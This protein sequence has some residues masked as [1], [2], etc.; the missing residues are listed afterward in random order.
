MPKRFSEEKWKQKEQELIE[1]AKK[2]PDVNSDKLSKS[3]YYSTFQTRFDNNMGLL[4]KAAELPETIPEI[5]QYVFEKSLEL[6]HPNSLDHLFKADEIYS[7][8]FAEYQASFGRTSPEENYYKQEKK[9]IMLKVLNTLDPKEEKIIKMRFYYGMSLEGVA[10]EF[11]VTKERI[12][13]IEAKA[14]RRLRHLSRAN[15]LRELLD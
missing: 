14:L 7:E 6:I 3:K 13:Q 1:Y 15:I 8:N 4:R 2:N 12:R 5:R 9:K 10:E 11:G